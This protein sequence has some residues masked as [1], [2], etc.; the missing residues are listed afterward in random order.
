MTPKRNT[1]YDTARDSI[2]LNYSHLPDGSTKAGEVCPACQG[3][4]SKERSL[5]VSRRGGVLLF[6]CHRNSCRF[7]GTE[8]G[9]GFDSSKSGAGSGSSRRRV[10]TTSLD[11]ATIGFMATKFGIPREVLK[12]AGLG[13]TGENDDRY[14]RRIS[15]PIYGPDFRKRGYSYRSYQGAKPKSL[16]VLDEDAVASSWYR[17]LRKSKVLVLVEDQVSAIKLAPYV[18]SLALLGTNLSDAK[19]E[20]INSIT[21]QYEQVYISL[22]N[23]ATYEA[24]KMQLANRS[25]IKG[26]LVAALGQDI[27]DMNKEDFDNYVQQLLQ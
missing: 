13:W 27:K 5:S 22:D 10:D 19:V 9:G 15:F 20:E 14:G 2:I 8:E 12:S 3:G 16:I 1:I 24:I 23:D 17:W 6:I 18:H 7:R 26:L 4:E 25:K 21:P 11:D